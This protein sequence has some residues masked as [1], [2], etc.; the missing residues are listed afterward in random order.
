MADPVL[1]V[2]GF[3]SSFDRNWRQPGWADL[4]A[5]A[6][7]EVIGIDLLGHGEADKPHD[8]AAYADLEGDV[9]A[10][11]PSE[12]TIDA[13]G[14]SLGARVLLTVAATHPD[15]FARIV[16]GGLGANLFA[17]GDPE[18]VAVAIESG[19]TPEDPGIA[20]LFAQFALGSGNDPKALAACLRRT[21]PPVTKAQLAAITCRVLVVLGDKDFAGPPEP[22]VEALPNATLHV[23]PG[24]DHFA[25]PRDFG[26]IDAALGFLD[27]LPS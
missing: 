3:A 20:R 24:V 26:F 6:G 2:H 18:A 8:P 1:L 10:A 17:Q 27:A 22:L 14:F 4:L 13:I 23:L 5:D 15:R 19:A 9:A 25:A 11:L 21:A 16:L 7:R 12:G